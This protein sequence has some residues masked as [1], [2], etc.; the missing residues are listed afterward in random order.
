M[1]MAS[2]ETALAAIATKYGWLKLFTLGASLGGAAL[3]AVFRP[4]KTRKEMFLQAVVAL[5]T[6]L[7]FGGTIADYLDSIFTF[8]DLETSPIGKVIQFQVTVHGM[9]GALS[10]GLFGGLAHMR[11]KVA[12]D[13]LQA[14]KDV[15]D[16][17]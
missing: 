3:M 15:K 5:G 13:P 4:P 14:I 8:I 10:W 2:I 11:D 12:K 6:S 1:K 7:L 16:V 9:L 17:L